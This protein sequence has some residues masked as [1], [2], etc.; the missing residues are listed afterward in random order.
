MLFYK[1]IGVKPQLKRLCNVLKVW[2][3]GSSK[4]FA[5]AKT[6]GMTKEMREFFESVPEL[7]DVMPHIPSKYLRNNS[8]SE[9]HYLI[10]STIAKHIVDKIM[11]F[12]DLSG[13]QLIAETNAGL[14]LITSELLEK[15]VNLVRMYEYCSEF[16]VELRVNTFVC[17]IM[18]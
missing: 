11:P 2:N 7:L 18:I 15:G 12:L 9:H 1:H 5:T 10:S 13:K 17:L 6:R 8:T 4:Y 14:G 16:R 3:I